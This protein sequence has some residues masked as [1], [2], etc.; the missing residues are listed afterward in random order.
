MPC[1][2]LLAALAP[3]LLAGSTGCFATF[4]DEEDISYPVMHEPGACPGLAASIESARVDG[5]QLVVT[6]SYGGCSTPRIWACWDGTFLESFPVQAP[7]AIHYEPG[8][9]CDALQTQT[10]RFDL[11]AVIDAY[12]DAY[13]GL[14]PI[15]LNVGGESVTWEP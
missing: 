1:R 2:S 15:V 13:G 14:D 8:G 12:A 3:L 9:S 4:D 10:E 7:I 5:D 6:M 11:G